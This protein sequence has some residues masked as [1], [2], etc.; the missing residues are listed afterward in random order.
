MKSKYI[1][2]LSA[3][4]E[5]TLLPSLSLEERGYAGLEKANDFIFSN[6]LAFV[7]GLLF[8]QSMKSSIAWE[9]P[10]FLHE[11]LGHL[12]AGRMALL[13]ESF[14]QEVIARK[15]ALHRYPGTI[16][17]HIISTCATIVSEFSGDASS[18][19][20]DT[21]HFVLVK[22]NFLSLRGIGEKKA[23]LAILMLARDFKIRFDDIE[24]FPLAIDIHLR[25]VLDRSG[26]F[27]TDSREGL[28]KLHQEIKKGYP[29]FPALL[30]TALWFIG[31]H[32]CH[33]TSPT[34]DS[35]P[36]ASHCLKRI[37]VNE[38]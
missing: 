9:G 19:W 4:L 26:L 14:L 28:Q 36:I 32:Y 20:K 12:D 33:E 17:K 24:D 30:G 11:R 21:S 34:C 29:R 37:M 7:L 31:R 23:N 18:L 6:P 22:R 25:R 5:D 15:K 27:E 35:C 1:H 3:L 8:D 38:E 13:D 10:F 2:E 16:A